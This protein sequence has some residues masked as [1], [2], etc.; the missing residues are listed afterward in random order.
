M[1]PAYQLAIASGI[2][3]A[4]LAAGIMIKARSSISRWSFAAGLIVLAVESAFSALTARGT[5][6]NELATWEQWRLFTLAF[7]PGP[8][9]VFTLTYARGNARDFL[10][11]WRYVLAAAFILPPAV[12]LWGR[13]NLVFLNS[14]AGQ[15][16][17]VHL[18]LG[19]YGLIL[20]GLI[21]VSAVL[22]LVNVE[23]TFVASVGTMRWR[24]KFMLLAVAVLFTV[25]FYT[26]SQALLYWQVDPSL[27]RLD[28]VAILVA[29]ALCLRSLFR[30]GHFDLDIY[31]SHSVLQNSFTILLVGVYLLTVGLLAK[32]A[33]LFG[34]GTGLALKAAVVLV[35]L[36]FLA[37]MLQSER[38]RLEARRFVSRH[39]QRPLYDYSTL[40]RKFTEGT[41]SRVEQTDLSRALVRLVAD[42]F[43]TLSVSLWLHDH[44]KEGFVLAASTNLTEAAGRNNVIYHADT[45]G[46]IE[47]F[48]RHPEPIDIET[49]Q[50]PW[51]A[52]LR[53]WQ[54]SEFRHGGHRVCVPL[55]GRDEVLGLIT[56]GDRVGGVG[57]STQDFEMLKCVGD[58]AAASLLNVQ[59]SQRLL[60]AKELEAFQTMATFFVHDLKNAASTLNL[61]LKNLP[62]HFNDPAFRE[63]A[64][65]GIGKTVTHIN[66]LIGRLGQLRHDLKMQLVPS[67]VNGVVTTA[68]SNLANTGEVTFARE[69]GTV[70]PVSLDR[71]QLLKVLTNLLLN[72]R[73]ATTGPGTVS[74]STALDG[75]WVVVSVTDQGCGMTSEFLRD[76]LFRPFQTTKKS[77]L[78]IGMFQSK[79]IVEAHHG[80]IAVAS[81]PGKGTTFRVLLPVPAPAR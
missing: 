65:R 58:H 51:A 25:R 7:L 49:T 78:G 64:L 68:L 35:S 20:H 74:V 16:L 21:L 22:I 38:L 81:Q 18:Q 45:A 6:V 59:L 13:T 27:E 11:R 24:I 5:H 8:W 47:H 61:M 14:G 79:M 28:S 36:V 4:L 56:L 54:P 10:R 75:A 26:S 67:D 73:E 48:R 63:D 1:S 52:Q 57:F 46:A 23:R 34:D 15:G 72:A 41:V 39:F 3:S 80:R 33:S 30:S 17:K 69:L 70:P 76:S 2:T 31:P 29:E 53:D 71:E 19:V 77:G 55:I 42:T 32:L 60:Q 9:L 50:A 12:A 43:Q 44:R 62:V 40:W 66:G 37:L